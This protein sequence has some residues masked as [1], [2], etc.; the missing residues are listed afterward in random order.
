MKQSF[1]AAAVSI[2]TADLIVPAS[3][4][5]SQIEQGAQHWRRGMQSALQLASAVHLADH[6]LRQMLADRMRK[7]R[8]VQRQR[9]HLIFEYEQWQQHLGTAGKYAA[10]ADAALMRPASHHVVHQHLRHRRGTG[11]DPG[12]CASCRKPLRMPSPMSMKR[13]FGSSQEGGRISEAL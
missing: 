7:C 2:T 13:R 1:R 6:A 11:G 4:T 9:L 12:G 8:H 10:L 3:V 5:R